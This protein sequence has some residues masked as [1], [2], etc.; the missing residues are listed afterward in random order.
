ML[1]NFECFKR[2]HKE[3]IEFANN[4]NL[5]DEDTRLLTNFFHLQN[6][7]LSFMDYNDDNS[8]N[9]INAENY[10]IVNS[11][12]GKSKVS[13]QDYFKYLEILNPNFAVIPFEYVI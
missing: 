10:F 5:K 12:N 11:S 8:D 4:Q 1:T 6:T 3:K 13:I 9:G 7:Y 2:F